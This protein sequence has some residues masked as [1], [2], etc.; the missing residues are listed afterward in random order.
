MNVGLIY[1]VVDVKWVQNS[2]QKYQLPSTARTYGYH[3][4]LQV[5]KPFYTLFVD[6]MKEGVA[7]KMLKFKSKKEK[8][9]K[10]IIEIRIAILNVKCLKLCMLY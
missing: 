1:P 10:F 8:I 9:W 6:R 4:Q 3:K 7:K 5:R 2:C